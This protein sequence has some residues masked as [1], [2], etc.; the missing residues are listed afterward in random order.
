MVNEVLTS[1]DEDGDAHVDS[2]ELVQGKNAVHD[3]IDYHTKCSWVPSA[4]GSKSLRPCIPL[5]I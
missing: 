4:I 5:V 3:N 1:L 2:A